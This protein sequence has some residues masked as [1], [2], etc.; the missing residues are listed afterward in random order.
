ML[1]VLWSVASYER[2]VVDWD[3]DPQAAIAGVTWVIGLVED[4]IR[5]AIA[6]GREHPSQFLADGPCLTSTSL[7]RRG[8][9]PMSIETQPVEFDP[10]SDSFFNDPTEMY[11]RFRDE[12]PVSFSKKYGFYALSRFADVWPRTGTGRAS[13]AR[14]ASSSSRSRRIRKRSP[15][16]GS[17]S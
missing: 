17:S 5:R 11:R 14:T 9:R 8:S 7:P 1:D 2:L 13:R 4:A 6:P 16:S 12:A 15:A 3:L 10:F